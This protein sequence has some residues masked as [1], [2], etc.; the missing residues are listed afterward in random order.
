[1]ERA[2]ATSSFHAPGRFIGRIDGAGIGDG[3]QRNPAEGVKI[4]AGTGSADML[5]GPDSSQRIPRSMAWAVDV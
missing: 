4:P 1:M 5:A 3:G 2:D